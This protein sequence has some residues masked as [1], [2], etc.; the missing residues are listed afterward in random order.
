MLYCVHQLSVTW[1]DCSLVGWWSQTIVTALIRMRD[2][3]HGTDAD[4]LSIS[5]VA[6]CVMLN[7]FVFVIHCF[8]W[9]A[10]TQLTCTSTP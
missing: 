8:H 10:Q 4:V 2:Y 5:F 6:N 9:I 3:V 1:P 7:F